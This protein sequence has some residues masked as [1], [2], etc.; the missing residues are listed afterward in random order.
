MIQNPPDQRDFAEP[1]D[2]TSRD[3]PPPILSA[4]GSAALR[5]R[6]LEFLILWWYHRL[7]NP[8]FRHGL[9]PDYL[10]NGRSKPLGLEVSD[11][12][13]ER[14]RKDTDVE[15]RAKAYDC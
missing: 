2:T 3:F 4:W 1:R 9:S 14:I 6:L 13:V 5:A 11:N 15:E 7:P 12:E 10:P 8:T